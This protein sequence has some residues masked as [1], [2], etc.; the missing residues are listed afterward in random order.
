MHCSFGRPSAVTTYS[1]AEISS[2]ENIISE[3]KQSTPAMSENGSSSRKVS[4]FQIILCISPYL[5]L[6]SEILD[7]EF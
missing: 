3:V 1:T 5:V 4:I 2:S 7:S 6:F